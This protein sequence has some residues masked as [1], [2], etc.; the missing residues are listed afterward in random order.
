MPT[1]RHS[2]DALLPHRPPMILLDEVLSADETSLTAAVTIREDSLFIEPGGVPSHIGIEYMAQACGAYAGL[3]ALERGEPVRVGFLL[4]TR[5]YEVRVPWLR[6]GDSMIVSVSEIY[7]DTQ[8]GA[9]KCRIERQ[10]ELVAT[11]QLSV[12]Q[13]E[14][15]QSP[16]GEPQLE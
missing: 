2:I 4:G 10:G 12:Y 7:R 5:R 9:F 11:A 16:Q 14:D 13:P 6:L 1:L 15:V 8:M 3:K